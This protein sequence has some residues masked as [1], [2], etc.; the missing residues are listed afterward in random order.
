MVLTF[1]EY[2]NF[3]DFVKKVSKFQKQIFLFSFEPKKRTNIFLDFCP[4][5]VI[6]SLPS[7]DKLCVRSINKESLAVEVDPDRAE[8]EGGAVSSWLIWTRGW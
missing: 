2:L 7:M 4:K 3:T 6:K 8:A 5:I 1:L